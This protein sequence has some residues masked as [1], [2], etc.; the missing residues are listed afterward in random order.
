M[1][2]QSR[3]FALTLS[4]CVLIPMAAQAQNATVAFVPSF[5][6]EEGA[7]APKEKPLETVTRNQQNLDA[8]ETAQPV[9]RNR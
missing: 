1:S 4:L 8:G 7:F 6:P 3:N 9:D 5:W 2:D